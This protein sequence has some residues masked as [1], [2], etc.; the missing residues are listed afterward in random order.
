MELEQR[1]SAQDK[2]AD[3][4]GTLPHRGTLQLVVEECE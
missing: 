3:T 2:P 4:T 1:S